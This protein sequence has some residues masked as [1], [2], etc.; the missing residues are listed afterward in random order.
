M[1]KTLSLVLFLLAILFSCKKNRNHPPE[2]NINGSWVILSSKVNT[3]TYLASQYPCMLNEHV[4][5][6]PN[7]TAMQKWS[8]TGQCWLNDAHTIEFNQGGPDSTMLIYVRSGNTIKIT[9]PQPSVRP[10]YGQISSTENKLQL[11][12][13][14]TAYYNNQ[15]IITQATYTKE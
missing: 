13:A 8:Y 15:T 3:Q 11:S 4:I 2:F 7:G 10:E 9:Y 12:L 1:K 5:F 14:D 6:K